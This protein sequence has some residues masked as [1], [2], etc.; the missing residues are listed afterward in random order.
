MLLKG[1]ISE[2]MREE[3]NFW[4]GTATGQV[5]MQKVRA[6]TG[7]LARMP[8]NDVA[9]AGESKEDFDA[10]VQDHMKDPRAS[11]PTWYRANVESLF[12]KRYANGR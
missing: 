7:D 2:E 5:L 1:I 4:G 10:K 3:L 12:E 8:V 9:E 6:M 11:D